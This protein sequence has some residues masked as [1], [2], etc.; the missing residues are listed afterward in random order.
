MVYVV[1]DQLAL[2]LRAIRG[3]GFLGCRQIHMVAFSETAWCSNVFSFGAIIQTAVK[4]MA[5][6]GKSQQEG[7]TLLVLTLSRGGGNRDIREHPPLA[8]LF[9]SRSR[10]P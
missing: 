7:L 10:G 8:L 9:F 4:S 3:P 2:C 6:Q 1:Y 5:L